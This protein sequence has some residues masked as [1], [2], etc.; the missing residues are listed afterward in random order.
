MTVIFRLF[1]RKDKITD[2][3]FEQLYKL[4]RLPFI[5]FA[6]KYFSVDEE[7]ANDIYHDS[8]IA[9]IKN[10]KE[11]K[12]KE[13][14]ASIK[15]YLFAIGKNLLCKEVHRKEEQLLPFEYFKSL[16][17][18]EW[19]KALDTARELI[20]EADTTCNKVLQLFYWEKA[21]MKEIARQMGYSSEDVAKNKKM[22]CLRR[23]TFEL[24]KRLNEQDIYYKL[25]K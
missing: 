7:K 14:H 12:Y 25:K 21:S 18:P 1:N 15:T 19:D 22:S 4:Y 16:D 20:A 23:M 8:F 24:Q 11:G 9:L 17:D 5:N 3:N 6:I 13:Q 2:K 10:I